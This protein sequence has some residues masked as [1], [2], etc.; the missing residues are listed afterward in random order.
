MLKAKIALDPKDHAN[1]ND[2]DLISDSHKDN[3]T[4]NKGCS[5]LDKGN[6]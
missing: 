2:E 4:N 6:P 3:K 1:D 5:A